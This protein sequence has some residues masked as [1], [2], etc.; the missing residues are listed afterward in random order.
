MDDTA[1]LARGADAPPLLEVTIGE[2]LASAAHRWGGREALIS[3]EQ[4][5][6]LTWSELERR[7]R[8]LSEGLVALGLGPGDRIGVWSPNCAEWTLTQF[9]AARIGLILVTIN[10]A[11]RVTE[12]EYTLRKVGVRALVSAGR[13]KSSDYVG[14]VESLA[15]ELAAS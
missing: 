7:A 3:C 5:V 4:G 1:S 8:S 2:A 15:P 12:L 13:F 14:M 11:Y 6:R 10:P 9:A